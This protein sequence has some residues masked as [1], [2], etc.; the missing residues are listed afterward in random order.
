MSAQKKTPDKSKARSKAKAAQVNMEYAGDWIQG[1]IWFNIGLTKTEA[2]M[3]KTIGRRLF[4]KPV[5]SALV[6]R[7]LLLTALAH[8]DKLEP[9]MISD[10]AY[11]QAEG[12]LTEDHFL[13]GIIASQHAKIAERKGKVKS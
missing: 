2:P 5:K 9:M 4:N 8:Y 13:H 10:A 1:N 3:L 7:M 12:F 6:L 11:A